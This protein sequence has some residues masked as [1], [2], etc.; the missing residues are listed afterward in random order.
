MAMDLK[1]VV[2]CFK[3]PSKI[4]N[5][6]I[7]SSSSSGCHDDGKGVEV[8]VQ[9][10]ISEPESE[11]GVGQSDSVVELYLKETLSSSTLLDLGESGC[12]GERGGLVTNTTT[13]TKL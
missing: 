12:N 1:T 6:L 9:R 8:Q 5:V 7:G 3:L 13:C 11:V 10:S 4:G 2:K